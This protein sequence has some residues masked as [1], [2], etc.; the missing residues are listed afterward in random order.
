M[1]VPY[2]VQSRYQIA[3][4]KAVNVGANLTSRDGDVTNV[5]ADIM[6]FL[7]V[8]VSWYNTRC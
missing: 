3:S 5:V 7:L 8:N 2:G 1:T 4:A 6:V